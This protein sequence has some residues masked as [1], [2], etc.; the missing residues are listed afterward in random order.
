MITNYFDIYRKNVDVKNLEKLINDKEQKMKEYDEFLTSSAGSSLL[1]N[2]LMSRNYVLTEKAKAQDEEEKKKIEKNY[3]LEFLALD[4]MQKNVSKTL[5]REIKK[6][7]LRYLTVYYKDNNL[8]ITKNIEFLTVSAIK[9]DE[10]TFATQFSKF[11]NA[12]FYSLDKGGYTQPIKLSTYMDAKAVKELFKKTMNDLY[13]ESL[14]V[15][16]VD[17]VKDSNVKINAENRIN[18]N[19]IPAGI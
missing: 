14:N 5:I 3:A 7:L 11:I 1:I 10:K 9:E 6:D 15:I 16:S 13:N 17:Y 12:L 8:D 18:I 19:S 4:D 2:R